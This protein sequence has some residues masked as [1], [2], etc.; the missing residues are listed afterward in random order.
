[1]SAY[2]VAVHLLIEAG[3]APRPTIEALLHAALS[4]RLRQNAGAGSAL[5]DWAVAGE[6]LAASIVRVE[7]PEPYVPDETAFPAWPAA[8]LRPRRA[9]QGA[10]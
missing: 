7:L 3:P 6:D 1:M 4:D 2:V 10:P 8:S 5:I 9:R